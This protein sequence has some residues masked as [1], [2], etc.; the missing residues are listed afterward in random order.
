MYTLTLTHAY[1]T[2]SHPHMHRQSREREHSE[3]RKDGD[4]KGTRW[5][6]D[7]LPK[8][9]REREHSDPF[10]A[11]GSRSQSRSPGLLRAATDLPSTRAAAWL[12]SPRVQSPSSPVR[13]PF[14]SPSSPLRVPFE[15]P[16]PS[17]GEAMVM[18][19]TNSAADA[20]PMTKRLV[21]LS[22][23]RDDE[24]GENATDET[25]QA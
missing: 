20:I 23:M 6:L 24:E 14:E 7:Q 22:R 1:C 19:P 8:Q 13:V 18:T 17:P 5:G 11:H 3:P 15:G 10:G 4:S 25:V 9:S 12:Q 16:C 2:H 21:A